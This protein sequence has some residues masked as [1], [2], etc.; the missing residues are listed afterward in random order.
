[1]EYRQLGSSGLRVSRLALGAMTF[2]MPTWGCDEGTAASLIDRYLDAGGMFIDTADGYGVSEEICGRALA[3]RRSKV[4]VSTKVGLPIAQ[5]GVNG[6]GASRKH[7]RESCEASL[8]RL[9]TD[10]IDLYH[11]HVEDLDTP[12]EET[13]AVLDDLV[14]AGKVLYLGVSNIRAYRLM[15]ALAISERLGLARFVSLQA[16]YNLVVRTMEREHFA[17][18][19]EEGLGF[20]S[21]SPL[22]AGLLSGKFKDGAPPPDT[23]LKQRSFEADQLFLNEQGLRVAK[24]VGQVAAELGCSSAQL[25]LAWQLACPEVDAVIIGVRTLRQLDDNL[26]CLDV[27]LTPDAIARIEAPGALAPEY[28][29]AFIE[30][31]RHWMQKVRRGS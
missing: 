22:A 28:P 17:L 13:L 25:A 14:R 20:V 30:T 8:K 3:G 31:F 19:R 2:G 16:Q 9:Q 21:W 23:R 10:Y 1:M 24:V 27:R 18:L 11:V 7:I 29:G 5:Q 4:V 15:K 26:G 12:L 6:C